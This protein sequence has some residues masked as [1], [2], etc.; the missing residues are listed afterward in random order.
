MI[1][2]EPKYNVGDKVF[3]CAEPRFLSSFD[4]MPVFLCEVRSI[5]VN[6]VEITEKGTQS[7]IRYRLEILADQILD[8]RASWDSTT[9]NET[10]IFSTLKGALEKAKTLIARYIENRTKAIEELNVSLSLVDKASELHTHED[11]E[12]PIEE[13]LLTPKSRRARKAR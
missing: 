12:T 13:L 7:Q 1:T 9:V 2:I 11:S 5:E 6:K 10:E 4:I 3:I 8:D